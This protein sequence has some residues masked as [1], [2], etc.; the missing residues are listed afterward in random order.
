[1]RKPLV[2]WA[3]M[4]QFKNSDTWHVLYDYVFMNRNKA[5]EIAA[6]YKTYGYYYGYKV[7]KFV[8]VKQRKMEAVE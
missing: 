4:Y 2:L 8:E 6:T 5:R 3:V 1:M 7:V